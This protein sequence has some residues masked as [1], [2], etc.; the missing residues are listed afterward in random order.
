[1]VVIW[2]TVGVFRA[3]GFGVWG[4]GDFGRSVVYCSYYDVCPSMSPPTQRANP[5]N[6]A[7]KPKPETLYAKP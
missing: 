3:L 2:V 6:P 5:K 4:S 1:M 7:T